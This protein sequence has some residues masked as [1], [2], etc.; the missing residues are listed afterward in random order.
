MHDYLRV[1][2]MT[3]N[4]LHLVCVGLAIFASTYRCHK[5]NCTKK[6][7][8]VALRELCCGRRFDGAR[9]AFSGFPASPQHRSRQPATSISLTR[10]LVTGNC[11]NLW[12]SIQSLSRYCSHPTVYNKSNTLRSSKQ[13]DR[14]WAYKVT[15]L[16]PYSAQ[17][18]TRYLQTT[19]IQK[20][21]YS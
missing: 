2:F 20:H 12:A 6:R 19:I 15:C 16:F 4:N 5:A 8:A 17:I 21:G 10:D 18:K 11:L 13:Q 1:L 9:P 14:Q 3:T 7:Y